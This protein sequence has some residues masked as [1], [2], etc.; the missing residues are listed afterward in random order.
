MRLV[1]QRV[2]SASV[3]VDGEVVGSIG[4]GA[5]LLCGVTHTDTEADA[6]W[7]AKKVAGLRVFSDQDGRMNRSLT[8]IGG[9]ALAV[10]NFTLYG[11]TVHGRRPEFM[12][13]A[14]PD[15]A[16]PLFDTFVRLLR[17]QGVPTATGRFG[18]DMAVGMDGDGP[19]TILF[20]TADCAAGKGGSL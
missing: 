1:F 15:I 10:S 8:D 11:N 13:A 18:A 16:R 9:E 19:V 3:T 7:L 12:A 6:L 4:A 5:L 17:E 2:R 20:D 14:K